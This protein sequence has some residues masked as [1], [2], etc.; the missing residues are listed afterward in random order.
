[1]IMDK[2]KKVFAFFLIAILCLM[3]L[4]SC[5]SEEGGGAPL[6]N[7]SAN[8]ILFLYDAQTESYYVYDYVGQETEIVVP[9]EF[10]D[11][12]VAKIGE[13]AFKGNSKIK[14]VTLPDSIN[15]IGDYAFSGCRILE[16][17]DLGDG[18]WNIGE[19]AF[20]RCEDLKEIIIPNTLRALPPLAFSNCGSL[21]DIVVKRYS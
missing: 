13:R 19:Y 4:S 8:G 16:S 3:T 12:P 17:I 21:T 7:G 5:D 20:A 1:M 11:V 10:N 6:S 18:V 9:S 2:F 15:E 14:S